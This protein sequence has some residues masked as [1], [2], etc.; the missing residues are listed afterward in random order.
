MN[1]QQHFQ[2]R[3]PPNPHNFNTGAPG[4]S[5][6]G[7]GGPM[8]GHN[9]NMGG[10]PLGQMNMGPRQTMPGPGQFQTNNHSMPPQHMMGSGM[11]GGMP[12]IHQPSE[13]EPPK[14]LKVELSNKERGYYSNLISKHESEGSNRIDGKKA[15]TFFKTSGVDVNTLK[16][17]WRTCAR[18]NVESLSREEF[19]VAL[20]LIAYAQNGIP[21]TEDSIMQN[22]E[23]PFPQF[24]DDSRKQNMNSM[25]SSGGGMSMPQPP[26]L[27]DHLPDLNNINVAALNMNPEGSLLPGMDQHLRQKEAQKAHEKMST[28]QNSPWFLKQEDV[29]KYNSFFDH[30]NK[31][32]SGVLTMEETKQ[33]F[34]QTQLDEDTLEQI[35]GLA[36]PEEVGEF[37]RQ[38]F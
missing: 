11:G 15:V 38:M 8:M 1:N 17:I 36:D 10:P 32:G 2:Q 6:M 34:M 5:T 28:G 22:I 13:P 12:P 19:Y 20:R 21:P 16:S 35:W 9:P 18:S 23:A 3:G 14:K 31:S 24:R 33:A 30:F 37:D 27:A 29:H 4:R 26:S 7:P 25:D